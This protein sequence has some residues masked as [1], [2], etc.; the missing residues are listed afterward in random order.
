MKNLVSVIALFFLLAFSACQRTGCLLSSIESLVNANPDSAWTLLNSISDVEGLD[1]GDRAEYY[2]QLAHTK[3]KRDMAQDDDSLLDYSLAYYK[4]QNDPHKIAMCWLYKGRA[5]FEA[6]RYT[7]AARCYKEAEAMA[8]QSADEKMLEFVYNQLGHVHYHTALFDEALVLYRKSLTYSMKRRNAGSIVSNLN[9]IG[10]SFVFLEHSDSAMHYFRR[11]LD[12]LADDDP[13]SQALAYYNLG[14]FL[15]DRGEFS[16]ASS[17][18]RQSVNKDS[19]ETSG[20]HLSY[21][22]LGNIYYAEGK[23]DSA[24]YFWNKSLE[25]SDYDTRVCTY[26]YLY[27]RYLREEK[28]KEA[29]QYA[30]L[31]L[32]YSDSLYLSSSAKEVANIQAKYDNLSLRSRQLKADANIARLCLLV[33]AVVFSSTLSFWWF[34]HRQAR[35]KERLKR[36]IFEKEQELLGLKEDLVELQQANLSYQGENKSLTR[37]YEEM[38]LQISRKEQE[39]A[40]LKEDGEKQL[41]LQ[42]RQDTISSSVGRGFIQMHAIDDYIMHPEKCPKVLT[43]SDLKDIVCL[44]RFIEESF[45]DK[46]EKKYK[47]KTFEVAICILY[48]KKLNNKQVAEVMGSS[49]NTLGRTKT[50]IKAKMYGINASTLEEIVIAL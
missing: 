26:G 16:E 11:S 13:K 36:L 30:E 41:D 22:M 24:D 47:L 21:A 45:I 38:Q 14:V 39:I 25:T 37:Q 23:V 2:L 20:I 9:N 35:K 28:Y 10:R 6:N 43:V 44:Y 4:E 17:F 48:R 32:Q 34:Q 46:L 1:R 5:H 8:L 31:L 15:Y 18:I 40:L 3:Y 29:T 49:P 7:E 42:G 12:Y 33:L 50:R 27:N 19:T